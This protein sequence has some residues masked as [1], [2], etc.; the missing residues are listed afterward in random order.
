MPSSPEMPSI[1]ETLTI[2]PPPPAAIAPF[3]ARI[4]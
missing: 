2:A 4:P 1:D 3:T